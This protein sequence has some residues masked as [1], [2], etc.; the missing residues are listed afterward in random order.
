ML[1]SLIHDRIWI[2]LLSAE[3]TFMLVG[4]GWGHDSRQPSLP[5]TVRVRLRPVGSLSCFLTKYFVWIELARESQWWHVHKQRLENYY[6]HV[7][8]AGCEDSETGQRRK[9]Q[10]SGWGVWCEG[11]TLLWC[12]LIWKDEEDASTLFFICRSL[13]FNWRITTEFVGCYQILP[14]FFADATNAQWVFLGSENLMS[15]LLVLVPSQNTHFW[16]QSLLWNRLPSWLHDYFT[17]FSG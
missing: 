14:R 17:F 2:S 1:I 9:E 13:G 7:H 11:V 10:V 6:H 5:E 12:S 8:A 3:L 15:S 4:F 16:N